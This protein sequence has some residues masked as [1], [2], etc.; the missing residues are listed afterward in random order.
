MTRSGKK[1]NYNEMDN[2]TSQKRSDDF[3]SLGNAERE[4]GSGKKSL[5]DFNPLLAAEIE[6]EK[7]PL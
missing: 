1:R 2:E 6:I 7:E 3:N 4:N 5:N